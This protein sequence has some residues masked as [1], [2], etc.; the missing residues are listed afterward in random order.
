M[1]LFFRTLKIDSEANNQVFLANELGRIEV[2][3]MRPLRSRLRWLHCAE[4]LGYG[5]GAA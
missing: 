4:S 2:R 3:K 1:V 5:K